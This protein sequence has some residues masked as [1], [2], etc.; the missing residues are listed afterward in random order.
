MQCAEVGCLQVRTI[1][2]ALPHMR[3]A[4]SGHIINVTSLVGFAGFIGVD[5]YAASKFAV[6]PPVHF[7]ARI[8]GLHQIIA[9]KGWHTKEDHNSYAK[10]I[11]RASQMLPL[12]LRSEAERVRLDAAVG[13][14]P[15]RVHG[16]T[17]GSVR[18]LCLNCGTWASGD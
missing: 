13:G 6:S 4:R 14:G 1:Q 17:A 2:A 16:A 3:A 18:H 12:G 5:S 8:I 7:S 11:L 15:V 9:R 10:I